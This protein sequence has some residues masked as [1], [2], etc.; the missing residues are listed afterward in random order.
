MDIKQF[1]ELENNFMPGHNSCAGCGF[2]AIVRT[3]MKA[4]GKDTVACLATGCLEV[5]STLWPRSAWKVPCIHNTFENA[6]ATISG[7]EAAYKALKKKGKVRKQ[8]KFVAFAGDGGCYSEDTEIFTERGFI[9]IK[10]MKLGENIWSV[11][12]KTNELELTHIVKIFKYKVD[13]KMVRVRSRYIDFLVTPDHNVPIKLKNGYKFITAN[14]LFARYKTPFNRSFKWKG[15]RLNYYK[16]PK[17]KG[18]KPI[19]NFSKFK[20]EDWL[21]FLGWFITEG[22]LYKSKSGY[23]IRIYQSNKKNR[24]EILNLLKR[25]N[26]PAFECNRSVD[27]QSKQIYEL[28]LNDCGKYSKERKIPNWVLDLDRSLLKYIYESLMKGDGSVKKQKNRRIPHSKFITSSQKL[29]NNFVEL[30]L[31]LGCNCNVSFD[32]R[33]IYRIGISKQHLE[34]YIYTK[35]NLYEKQGIKQVK[36]ER[37]KGMVYCPQLYKNHT[38]IIKRNNKISLNGN[39]YD[40]GLQSLSGMLERRHDVVYVLYDN[41]GYMNCLARDSLIMAQSGLKK[42]IDI[43]KGEKVYAFDLK[44]HKPVLKK[45]S[46]IFDNGIKKVYELKTYHHSIKATSNHPFLILKRKG[47]GKT[48]ELVW[49]KLEN[50]KKGDEI[51]VSKNNPFI[52]KSFKF[53]PITISKKGDYKVNKINEIRLPKESSPNLMEILGL[54]VGD[55]WI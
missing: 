48:P 21:Q 26:L 55:G 36:E 12:P 41:E 3:I 10:N 25:M 46:G 6:A 24:K 52:S 37:Y 51:I 20:I 23:L 13:G 11:H 4:T 43:R 28:L 32:K 9:P 18:R 14:D 47:R 2:P 45:C 1:A 15:K 5:T 19:N 7:V 42:I 17:T 27:F 31:K 34:H 40:I 22:T 53:K 30:V 35:R 16:I 8:M 50:L 49:K 33:K 54:Y 29:M 39:S 38:V 44:S